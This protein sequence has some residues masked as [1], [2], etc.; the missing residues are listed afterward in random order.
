MRLALA[1]V[2]LV[3]PGLARAAPC[4][5]ADPAPAA[6]ISMATFAARLDERIT[7]CASAAR[8]PDAEA[9][10]A[11]HHLEPTP[12]RTRDYVVMRT[13]F[14]LARD[15]GPWRLRWAVTN[16]DP[17][18][19]DVWK[20]WAASPPAERSEQAS[21]TAE[22][23][24]LSAVQAGLARR[25]GVRQVGLFWPT[26][27]HTITAW[28]PAPGLRVLVPTS[29]IFQGCDATFDATTFDAGVQKTVFEF[30]AADVPDRFLVPARL[31]DFLLGQT[32][33]YAGASL[34]VL[35]ALR[36]HRA[37][38]LASSVPAS[39]LAKGA[40]ASTRALGAEDTRALVRYGV[41]ELGLTA[42]T[43]KD[44]LDRL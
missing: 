26:W 18:G 28:E 31:A 39:C 12:R 4:E 38:R 8:A 11:R 13:L 1:A 7:A 42:P 32:T 29:Q 30:P 15:G 19:K 16:K 2:L 37:V 9:F 3:S 25:L 43:A 5:E 36:A 6:G 34:D 14:E 33:H 41:T 21:A 20:A 23:D 22:C 17:S 27:N 40:I 35:A 24:E 44:V 10:H